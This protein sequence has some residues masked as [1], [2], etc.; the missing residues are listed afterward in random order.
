MQNK[1]YTYILFGLVYLGK[2]ASATAQYEG[3]NYVRRVDILKAY[4]SDCDE[5]LSNGRAAPPPQDM[6]VL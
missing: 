2:P 3:V 6:A 1:H 5:D 4:E